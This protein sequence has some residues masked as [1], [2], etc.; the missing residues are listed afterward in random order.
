MK[1]QICGFKYCTEYKENTAL[2]DDYHRN[3][4]QGLPL[5]ELSI[6]NIIRIDNDYKIIVI[7]QTQSKN[8]RK[9]VEPLAIQAMDETKYSGLP[10]SA[11]EP[12]DERDVHALLLVHRLNAIGLLVFEK[13]TDVWETD[14]EGYESGE[15]KKLSLKTPSWGIS[16]IWIAYDYRDRGITQMFLQNSL[17]YFDVSAENIAWFNPFSEDGK[18]LLKTILPNRIL[19]KY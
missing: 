4:T 7:N 14:W 2:H 18:R 3:F 9:I 1:C 12:F 19:I 17:N 8:I 10:Y 16:M 11:S 13:S 15:A 6:F 5:A